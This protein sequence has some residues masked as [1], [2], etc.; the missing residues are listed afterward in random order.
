[1][2]RLLTLV[3]IFVSLNSLGAITYDYERY[4]PLEISLID[5]LELAS[6]E[7]EYCGYI[8]R[9][10]RGG[11]GDSEFWVMRV[12]CFDDRY[13]YVMVFN[14]RTIE[15]MTQDELDMQVKDSFLGECLSS[16]VMDENRVGGK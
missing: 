15:R 1:M 12:S 2:K 10:W 9:V 5:A 13:F 14:D 6:K 16:R 3:F 7:V 11:W 8:N 4:R